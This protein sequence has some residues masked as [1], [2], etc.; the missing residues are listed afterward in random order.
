MIPL[1]VHRVF[2]FAHHPR[3][4]TECIR[5]FGVQFEE[6][7]TQVVTISPTFEI[8]MPVRPFPLS[9]I[10]VRPDPYSLPQL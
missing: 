5:C 10:L 2:L 8:T 4:G 9:P 7:T 6:R 3:E 1:Q